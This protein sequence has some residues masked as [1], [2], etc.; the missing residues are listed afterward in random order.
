MRVVFDG[1]L[2][3][4]EGMSCR[5]LC[6]VLDGE[7]NAFDGISYCERYSSKRAEKIAVP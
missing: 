5:I 2:C 1:E 4:W 6:C 7:K 3:R